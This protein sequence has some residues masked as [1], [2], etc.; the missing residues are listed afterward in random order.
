MAHTLADVRTDV[1]AY[2][3]EYCRRHLSDARQLHPDYVRM[4]RI[5]RDVQN[6]GG[7]RLRPYLMVLAYEGMG[8]KEYE[9]I[10]PVAAGLELLHIGLLI[11]DDII[12]RDYIRHGKPNVIGHYR[13]IYSKSRYASHYANSAAILAGDLALL[14]SYEVILES[15]L[16]DGGKL[17][18]QRRL[19][20]IL[21]KV[22]GGELLD[23][24]SVMASLGSVDTKLIMELKT[25][26]YSFCGPLAMGAEL[27]GAPP[28][29]IVSLETY[30][31]ALGVAFQL[32]DDILGLFGNEEETGKSVTSD[33]KE[34]KPTYLMQQT[35]ARAGQTD[36]HWLEEV[37]HSGSVDAETV[38]R[39]RAIAEA[40]GAKAETKTLAAE[41]AGK[42]RSALVDLQ[43]DASVKLQLNNLID[44][45]LR[46]RA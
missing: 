20:Y 17:R 27:V 7:K 13:K 14:G 36:R 11:H 8:G 21:A 42:A 31:L 40:T 26:S 9:K 29:A 37:L 19:G 32:I 25:A 39:I 23:I 18:A 41:Y 30:G 6:A 24:E 10:V 38:T 28:E 5:L 2:I 16:S 34:G 22:I 43:V 44:S 45:I 15:G 33:I 4:W 3:D 1:E 12:D 46:R 35:L